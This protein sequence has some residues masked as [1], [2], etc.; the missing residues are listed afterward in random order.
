MKDGKNVP[1]RVF[2]VLFL[3]MVVVAWSFTVGIA[4][5]GLLALAIIIASFC[6]VAAAVSAL[7]LQAPSWLLVV[8]GV[9]GLIAAAVGVYF[10]IEE[11]DGILTPMLIPLGGG[12]VLAELAVAVTR[13]LS[14]HHLQ[15]RP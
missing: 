1:A 9:V 3:V 4:S 12:I 10:R 11:P 5:Y 2:L 13:Y 7:T 15:D 6:A 14:G 8:A